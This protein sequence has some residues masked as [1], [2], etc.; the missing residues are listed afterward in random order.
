MHFTAMGKK[1]NIYSNACISFRLI[2]K[3]RCFML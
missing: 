3:I 1:K 2:V